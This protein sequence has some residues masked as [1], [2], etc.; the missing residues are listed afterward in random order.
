MLA[1]IFEVQPKIEGNTN[2]GN[3]I[4]DESNNFSGRCLRGDS[5]LLH[6]LHCTWVGI[7][8]FP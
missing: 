2:S 1:V 8:A 5:E 6:Q 7:Q 4:L 3:I